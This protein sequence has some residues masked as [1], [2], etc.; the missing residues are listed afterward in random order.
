MI[1]R[2]DISEAME[3]L[4]EKISDK[5]S[6]ISFGKNKEIDVWDSDAEVVDPKTNPGPTKDSTFGTDPVVKT[7][8][9]GKNSNANYYDWTEKPPRQVSKKLAKA[10][11]GVAIKVFKVK[12]LDK[13]VVSG[14]FVLKYHML[15]IQSPHLVNALCPIVKEQGVHLEPT[16]VAIFY[17]PFRPLY[18]CSDKIMSLYKKVDEGSP[19]KEHLGLLLKVMGEVFG[20]THNHVKNLQTSKLIS[21]KLAWAFYLKDSLVYSPGKDCERIRKVVDTSYKQ[22]PGGKP[23]LVIKCKEIV[24]DGDAFIWKNNELEIGI[25]E[26]NKP[27]TELPHY[28]LSFHEDPQ[29]V[30]DTLTARGKRVLDY[31]GLTYLEYEGLAIYEDDCVGIEKHNVT[32]RIL[33]DT[34]GYNKHHLALQRRGGKDLDSMNNLVVMPNNN[35]PISIIDCGIPPAP[36]PHRKAKYPPLPNG[37]AAQKP[38]SLYIKRLTDEEQAKNKN[39]MLAREQDLIFLSPLLPGYALKNKLWCKSALPTTSFITNLL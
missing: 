38:K 39:D 22:S 10:N 27:I 4:K 36:Q 33:I 25:F 9:E 29:S 16:D 32:G 17:Y 14:R 1:H 13:P 12:D 26:G 24:F 21:F 30:A 5:I 20:G 7:F 19:L 31:Q 35:D 18:F 11:D 23:M 2:S 28:P 8:Y 15:E 6:S 37:P 3:T 34:Y